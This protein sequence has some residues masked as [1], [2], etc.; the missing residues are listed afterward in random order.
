MTGVKKK[1]KKCIS[2]ILNKDQDLNVTQYSL[3]R[4]ENFIKRYL[5]KLLVMII[6]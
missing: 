2:S 3:Q 4:Q 1:L 5:N 6:I